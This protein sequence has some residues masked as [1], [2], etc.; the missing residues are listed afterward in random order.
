M[1]GLETSLGVI[2]TYLVDPGLITYNELVELM[3]IK[4]SRNTS[5][6]SGDFKA[7]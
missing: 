2:L 7:G 4:T 6:R 5:S 1:T 3:A